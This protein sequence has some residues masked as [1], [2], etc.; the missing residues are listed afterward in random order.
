MDQRESRPLFWHQNKRVV[1]QCGIHVTILK[2]AVLAAGAGSRKISSLRKK[3]RKREKKKKKERE[4]GERT[5][6]EQWHDG[7]ARYL[8]GAVQSIS[9]LLKPATATVE[10]LQNHHPRHICLGSQDF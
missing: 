4:K 1:V 9:Q 10:L 5:E 7:N 2:Y 3:E 6:K 8:R